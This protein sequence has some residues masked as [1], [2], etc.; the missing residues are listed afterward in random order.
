MPQIGNSTAGIVE[1]PL[2]S[3][4]LGLEN[5]WMPKDPRAAV[6][7]CAAVGAAGPTFDGKFQPWQTGGAGAGTIAPEATAAFP[8]P[9]PAISHADAP[10]SLLPSYTP[11]G[12]IVT[13]PPPTFAPTPTKS[14]DPGNGWFNS[15][16]TAGA[17]TPIAGCSYPP[18]WDAVNADVPPL[19]GTATR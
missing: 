17:P 6:G 2:W 15:Q 11:T 13:L 12:A 4:Q 5:G 8:W 16:D 14:I 10:V 1:A 7:M 18:E 9:P 19:C 3:Y